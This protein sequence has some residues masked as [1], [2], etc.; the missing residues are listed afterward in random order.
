MSRGIKL[1]TAFAVSIV[2][3]AVLYGGGI[4]LGLTLGCAGREFVIY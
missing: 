2:A 4:P 1:A 3:F